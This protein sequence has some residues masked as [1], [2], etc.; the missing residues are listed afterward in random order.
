ML[1]SL[2]AEQ[3]VIKQ[4]ARYDT[5]VLLMAYITDLTLRSI[6]FFPF[7]DLSSV[8]DAVVNTIVF[9]IKMYSIIS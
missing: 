5:N 8:N 6:L 7:L 1:L 9:D 4:T 2:S 3:N